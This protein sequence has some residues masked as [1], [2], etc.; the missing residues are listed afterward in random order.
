MGALLVELLVR[1][2]IVGV[3]MALGRADG[4][5][6][7]LGVEPIGGLSVGA[8]FGLVDS[9]V[10][11]VGVGGFVGGLLVPAL[12]NGMSPSE[13]AVYE[14]HTSLRFVDTTATL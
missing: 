10:A 6:T 1:G 8:S 14:M 7:G 11:G 2:S 3:S 5:V 4:T 13:V 12:D 9:A